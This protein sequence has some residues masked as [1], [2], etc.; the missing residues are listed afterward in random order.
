M[1]LKPTLDTLDGLEESLHSHYVE[2]D[3]KFV[4]DLDGEVPAPGLKNALDAERNARKLSDA[5]IAELQAK[6]DAGDENS[7]KEK[8]QYKELWEKEKGK[9]QELV[10]KNRNT[11]RS[12]FVKNLVGN[13][14]K[15]EK[16][17][18]VLKTTVLQH[19]GFDDQGQLS[20]QGLPEVDSLDK[21][22]DYCK[23]TYPFLIDGSKASGG[24]AP[25]NR[26]GGGSA[27]KTMTQSDFTKMTPAEKMKF[28]K[29]GGQIVKE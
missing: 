16:K 9:N 29:S 27:G 2:K 5:K 22:S 12:F 3:G 20:V 19:V 26:G 10:E 15:D 21:L 17:A 4:L 24:G 8:E 6:I 25:G 11:K 18:K 14:T 7:L 23:E 1:A 13:L 28:M